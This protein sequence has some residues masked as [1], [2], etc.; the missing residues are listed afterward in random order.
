[1]GLTGETD[2]VTDGA[3]LARIANG[4]PLMAKV[5]AMGALGSAVVA[6]CLAVETDAWLATAAALMVFGVAGE[7]AGSACDRARQLCRRYARRNLCA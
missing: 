4:H 2:L 1:M 3:R 6:A 5:T 7:I